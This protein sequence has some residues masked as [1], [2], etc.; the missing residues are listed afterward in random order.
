ML[1]KIAFFIAVIGY[2]PKLLCRNIV[3]KNRAYSGYN[4]LVTA[5]ADSLDSQ[6]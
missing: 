6:S 3:H 5:Q 4:Q 1:M 2:F